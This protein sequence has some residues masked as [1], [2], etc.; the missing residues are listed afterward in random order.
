M[1]GSERGQPLARAALGGHHG[2]LVLDK[3]S[4]P[5]SFK[6]MRMAQRAL[7]EKTAGHAGTLDPMAS[8]VLV[9][10]LGEGTKLSAQVM[11]H[12]KTYEAEVRFG[13]GTDTLDA[14]GAVVAE[15]PVP[16]GLAAKVAEVLPRFVGDVMQV[17]PRYSALKV[18]GRSNMSR[19]R[20][21]EEFEVAPRPA[22]CFELKVLAVGDDT[23]RLSIDCGKGYYVRS[24]ARDLGAAL[25]V[26]AHLAGLRRTRV[27]RF[28]LAQAVAPDAVASEHVIAIAD[29]TDLPH[30]VVAGAELAALRAGRTIP[31]PDGFEAALGLA[32]TTS[33]EPVA[34]VV[35]QDRRLKV[36]RGFAVAPN[37]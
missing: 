29:M 9:V 33:R 30:V 25:G 31:L 27:G 12:T 19:A 22:Q 18:E 11:D 6:A 23:V 7:G 3:P 4:G 28:T 35:P 24:L 13:V 5:T 1:I 20:A 15:A 8:G 17:P 26:P 34:L 16:D 21:G 32:I 36:Q 2:A 37:D 14:E 10:L